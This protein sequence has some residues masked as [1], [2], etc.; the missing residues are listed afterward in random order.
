MSIRGYCKPVTIPAA[1]I[2][3]D[4]SQSAMPLTISV[5]QAATSSDLSPRFLWAEIKAGRLRVVRKG[6]RTLVPLSALREFLE[7]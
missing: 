1:K 6:R 3:T 5:A 7:I 4:N 2:V